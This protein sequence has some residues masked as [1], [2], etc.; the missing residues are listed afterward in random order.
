ML[1]GLSPYGIEAFSLYEEIHLFQPGGN[2]PF[3]ITG[4]DF[5]IQDELMIYISCA[6]D[7]FVPV[8]PQTDNLIHRSL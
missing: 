8:L 4:A 1:Q 7:S 6:W 2:T 5:C 3:Y